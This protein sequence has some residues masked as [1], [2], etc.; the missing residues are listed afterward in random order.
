MLRDESIMLFFPSHYAFK[1]FSRNVPIM[2]KKVPIIPVCHSKTFAVGGSER[3][4]RVFFY[5][6]LGF[7]SLQFSVD[8]PTAP[9]LPARR[10]SRDLMLSCEVRRPR[11]ACSIMKRLECQLVGRAPGNPL[12]RF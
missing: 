7:D 1:Q 2:L 11:Q 4:V 8:C 3:L 10:D 6:L 12:A 9:A 5:T